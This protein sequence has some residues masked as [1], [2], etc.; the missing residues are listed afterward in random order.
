MKFI[1]VKQIRYINGRVEQDIYMN[2]EAIDYIGLEGG[3][4]YA[5]IMDNHSLMVDENDLH[6][7]LKAI[8]GHIVQQI[9]DR[10]QLKSS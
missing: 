10:Y 8:E 4:E 5:I 6:R 9:I 3:P 1:K 7:I 2:L